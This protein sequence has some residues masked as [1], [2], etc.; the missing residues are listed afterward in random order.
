M[1]LCANDIYASSPMRGLLADETAALTPDLQR[2]AG[3]YGLQISAAVGYRPPALPMLRY[4]VRLDIA[5]GRYAGDLRGQA[6][7]PLPFGTDSFSLVLLR[8]AVEVAP[9]GRRLLQESARVLAPGGVLALTG[10][11][12]LSG[13]LPWWL[14]R[15]RARGLSLKTPLGLERWLHEAELT[16][17]RVQRIGHPWPDPRATGHPG[18]LF[19]GGYLVI[20]RKRRTAMLPVRLTPKA[21]QHPVNAGLAPGA[22]RSAA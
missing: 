15:N 3:S 17:E 9:S 12:P 21:V 1:P 5:A 20:A 16:I 7:Q 4:W 8:H 11:H 22:R 13:W 18:G 14:W 2:C 19:G 6:D 10:M